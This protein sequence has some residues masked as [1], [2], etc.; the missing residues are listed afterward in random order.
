MSGF[1]VAKAEASAPQHCL[2]IIKGSA[3]EEKINE[4]ESI[5]SSCNCYAN[6]KVQRENETSRKNDLINAHREERE[7]IQSQI[8]GIRS[9][10]GA[11]RDAHHQE[12]VSMQNQFDNVRNDYKEVVNKQHSL[13]ERERQETS[14]V[15]KENS[16]LQ[17]LLGLSE[18]QAKQLEIQLADKTNE[19]NQNRQAL[20]RLRQAFLDLSISNATNAER[21]RV[22]GEQLD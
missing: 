7:N 9:E 13:I 14:I 4:I 10:Y 12:M 18:G 1:F 17:R 16:N 6:E 2:R 20:D 22:V 5:L 21:A 19:L 8:D 3:V 15:R 11:L